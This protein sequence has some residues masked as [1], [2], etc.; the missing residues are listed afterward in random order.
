MPSSNL[1]T[2]DIRPMIA[3]DGA[4]HDA[5]LFIDG[6][7]VGKAS[8]FDGRPNVLLIEQGTHLVII[9]NKDQV[10][11]QQRIFAESELKTIK[12]AGDK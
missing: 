3:I 10:L 12:L 2:V 6:L 1:K 11:Y 7:R 8:D 4:P 5:E 9:K